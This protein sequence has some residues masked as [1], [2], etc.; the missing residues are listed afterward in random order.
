MM[1]IKEFIE[2]MKTD[3]REYLPD[4]DL[5]SRLRGGIRDNK[6]HRNEG[7]E[8]RLRSEKMKNAE[9]NEHNSPKQEHIPASFFMRKRCSFP[10]YD[11]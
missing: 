6:P 1:D 10:L 5:R 4:D 7:R 8:I 11:T 2:N 9:K 3:V